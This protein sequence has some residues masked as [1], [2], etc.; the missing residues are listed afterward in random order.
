MIVDR[1]NKGDQTPFVSIINKVRANCEDIWKDRPD[2]AEAGEPVWTGDA[3]KHILALFRSG[4]GSMLAKAPSQKVA[5]KLAKKPRA[6]K[7]AGASKP[8]R[9]PATTSAVQERKIDPESGED[10]DTSSDEEVIKERFKLLPKSVRMLA[11]RHGRL[12][13]ELADSPRS[14]SVRDAVS[15]VRAKRTLPLPT[16]SS[17]KVG[18]ITPSAMASPKSEKAVK[19]DKVVKRQKLSA[20]ASKV[21]ASQRKDEPEEEEE[22]GDEMQEEDVQ[23]VARSTSKR[24]RIS[25][26]NKGGLQEPKVPTDYGVFGR[27][28]AQFFGF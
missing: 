15:S 6:P 25:Q 24:K 13:G 14:R 10:T 20:A 11:D 19:M 28:I 8:A 9:R 2:C 26:P 27:R 21:A 3:L 16:A 7:A 23:V 5:P 4:K 12:P 18:K 17:S 1:G 22:A